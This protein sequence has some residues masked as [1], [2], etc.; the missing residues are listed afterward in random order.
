MYVV[1]TKQLPS[2]QNCFGVLSRSSQGTVQRR[3]LVSI[4]SVDSKTRSCE[5]HAAR[6]MFSGPVRQ[7]TEIIDRQAT[8]KESYAQVLWRTNEMSF[9][10]GKRKTLFENPQKGEKS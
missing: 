6:D 10:T 8:F 3:L 9:K 7:Y 5:Q 1:I 2:F 4:I